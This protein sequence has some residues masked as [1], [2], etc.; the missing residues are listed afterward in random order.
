MP[1]PLSI[2]RPKRLS[3]KLPETLLGRLTLHLFSEVEGRVPVGRYQAFFVERI[4][5]YFDHERLELAPYGFP[6]GYFVRGPKEMIAT[7]KKE[8]ERG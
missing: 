7:L 1:R 4:M 2:D 6:E 8:L 3:L 5:E